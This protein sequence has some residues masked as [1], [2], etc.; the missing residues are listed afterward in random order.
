MDSIILSRDFKISNVQFDEKMLTMD[1]G[2]RMKYISYDRHAFMVQTPECIMPYGITNGMMDD[3]NSKKYTI[4]LSFRDVDSRPGLKRFFNMLQQLDEYIVSEAFNHQK[5][6]LKKNYPSKEVV[7]ALYVPII[8][9]AKDKNTGEITDAYPPTFKMK[10]PFIKDK[11]VCDF[12]N[13]EQEKI[14]GDSILSMNTK[15]ARSISIMK[16]NGLWFAGGKFG[17]SWKAI[18]VQVA[19]K[20][21]TIGCAIVHCPD[22]TMD[23]EEEEEEEESDHNVGEDED[24]DKL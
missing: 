12:Y 2:L 9:Y 20:M 8:K 21:N 15:G 18:Q 17:C 7:E 10:V 11:F 19:P 22:D 23:G 1:T 14:S 5:D 24:D 4:D 13:Y 16:C 3:E 6:W